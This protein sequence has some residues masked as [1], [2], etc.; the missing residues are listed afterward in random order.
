MTARRLHRREHGEISADN[1][2]ALELLDVAPERALFV[3]DSLANDVAGARALGMRTVQALWFN[4]DEHAE[5][6]EPD[7]RAFTQ[8]DVLNIAK[9][10]SP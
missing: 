7:Y 1:E 9:R 2:R 5:G 6:G 8:M 4:A 3:G 10:L